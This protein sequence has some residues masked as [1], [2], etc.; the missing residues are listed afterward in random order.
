MNAAISLRAQQDLLEIVARIRAEN[1]FA[2]Q[3]LLKELYRKFKLLALQPGIGS[4]T[5]NKNV[6]VLPIKRS[7][8]VVY[9]SPPPCLIIRRVIHSA[10]HWPEAGLPDRRGQ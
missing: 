3:K 10:R 2:A 7:Y 4:Q 5:Q 9:S 6:R 1:P 8:K